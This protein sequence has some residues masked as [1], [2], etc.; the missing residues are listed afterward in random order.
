VPKEVLEIG[1]PEGV[2]LQ[3]SF[4]LQIG[5]SNYFLFYTLYKK[6]KEKVLYIHYA[7]H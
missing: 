3:Q 6:E 1:D 4:I 2:S 5:C 7:R